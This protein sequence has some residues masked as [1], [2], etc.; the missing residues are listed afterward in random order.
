MR[1]LFPLDLFYPAKIGGQANTL[2]WLSK[3][4]IRKGHEVTVVTTRKGIDEGGVV[5]DKWIDVNGIR[6]RY[7]NTV[8]KFPLSIICHSLSELKNV[9]TVIF[10]S[11]CYVPNFIIALVS[12]LRGHKVIWSPRGELF[13]SAVQGS[14][15]KQIYFSLIRF[16]LGRKILFHATSEEEKIAIQSYFPKARI[17]V[18]P[19]YMEMPQ[20]E[21][22][23]TPHIDFLYVGRMS[24]I[25]ALD[26][27]IA[28]LGTSKLFCNSR[29]NF[30][31]VGSIE[32]QFEWYYKELTEQIEHLGLKEKV[33]LMGS[34]TGKEKFKAYAS[35]RYSFLLSNSENF[36]NVV[37]EALSQGTPVVASKGTPWQKLS[38]RH[39]GFWI[40]NSPEEIAET[41]DTIIKQTDDEYEQYRMNALELAKD[42]DVHDHV[43]EWERIL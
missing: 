20:K 8:A 1:V 13:D 36:G 10:S 34:L 19:N 35:A 21:E 14:K 27:L 33:I 28:G 38:E 26:K 16:I 6:T 31:M 43:N 30:K 25:K 11:I 22:G 23:E 29:H 12:V 39:A 9:D 2:F 41:I 7:C 37:I 3:A 40:G 32:K 24:P 4:L 5:L 17:V 42:F 18:I 15:G